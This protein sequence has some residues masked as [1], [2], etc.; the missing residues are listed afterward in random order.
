MK[1]IYD[2]ASI[3]VDEG[4]KNSGGISSY[5]FSLQLFY[6]TIDGNTRVIQK[7]YEEEDWMLYTVK[8][9]ALKTSC[10]IIGD[11][12]LSKKCE[13]LEK[14]GNDLD[15]G[16]IKAH[17]GEMISEY[18]TYLEELAHIMDKPEE[19]EEEKEEI[20]SDELEDAYAALRELI[21]NMDYDSVEMILDQLK[22]YKLPEKDEETIKQLDG[23][24]KQFQWDEMEE[25]LKQGD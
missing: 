21:P 15:I 13:D 23:M 2:I 3:D 19:E 11:L 17:T 14:A 18:Q 5:I 25:L 12:E 22:E 24:L 6:E 20:P 16:F 7:A 4:I 10:R 8:V 9:H 1:W